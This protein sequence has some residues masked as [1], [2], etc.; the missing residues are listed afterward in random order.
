MYWFKTS[1]EVILLMVKN[2]Y[3]MT[4]WTPFMWKE[5][6]SLRAGKHMPSSLTAKTQTSQWDSTVKTACLYLAPA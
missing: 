6:A 4:E 2:D 1:P 3:Y 5:F